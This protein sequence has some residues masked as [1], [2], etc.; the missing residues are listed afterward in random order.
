MSKV[1]LGAYLKQ[2]RLKA[3]Y[4]QGDVAEYLGLQSAQSISDWERN[5]GSGIPIRS[6]KQ[7]VKLYRLD[8][9]KIFDL[10]L[11]YQFQ[12]LERSLTAEFYSP[13]SKRKGS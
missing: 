12:K 10:L 6:L 2:A 9:R 11:D 4:S 13:S 5:Y 3:G 8:S 1:D 7:L